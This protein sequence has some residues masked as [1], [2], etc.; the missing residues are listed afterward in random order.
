VSYYEL[1][2]RLF[3]YAF[4]PL[5]ALGTF[6][7]PGAVRLA[8]PQYAPGIEAAQ[9]MMWT[10]FFLAVHSA[11][12]PF[13]AAAGAFPTT[14]KLFPAVLSVGF[15]VQFAAIRA[16]AGL[17]GAAWTSLLTLAVAT[18]GELLVA[19]SESGEAWPQ[20]LVSAAELHLPLAAS[21]ALCQLGRLFSVGSG[22]GPLWQASFQSG[23]FLL[24]YA[25]VFLA[26]ERRFAI[27]R[28]LRRPAEAAELSRDRS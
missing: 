3:S 25:P 5:L 22:L 28:L 13:I 24:L 15:L 23:L 9:V 21:I 11:V 8:L 4:P 2:L 12:G 1:P 27:L 6:A 7:I 14:L 17:T 10:L 16:G 18:V 19:K 26:Y 20:A